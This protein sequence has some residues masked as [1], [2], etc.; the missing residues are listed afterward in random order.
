MKIN[1]PL[2]RPGEM[3]FFLNGRVIVASRISF[4]EIPEGLLPRYYVDGFVNSY[5]E[6][7]LFA[8]IS[9]AIKA[10]KS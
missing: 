8:D 10:L 6:S 9:N 5:S 2:Y 4:I 1:Y 7:S 3:V